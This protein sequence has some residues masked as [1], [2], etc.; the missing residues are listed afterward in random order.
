MSFSFGSPKI[1][2]FYHFAGM[3]NSFL[4]FYSVM[5][6]PRFFGVL[7]LLRFGQTDSMKFT[8]F[9][10]YW[11]WPLGFHHY[12]ET[13]RVPIGPLAPIMDQSL[14]GFRKILINKAGVTATSETIG[15]CLSGDL[16]GKGLI[17][18]IKH[19]VER[20]FLTI[21]TLIAIKIMV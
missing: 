12:T 18:Q 20:Y 1:V 15:N 2:L 17:C 13:D 5:V 9:I 19:C 8:L 11:R 3:I 4:L 16:G 10:F 7:L 21:L 14:L 6:C